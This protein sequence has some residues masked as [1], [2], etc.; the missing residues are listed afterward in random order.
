M[1][2]EQVLTTQGICPVGARDGGA[3]ET[4]AGPGCL[5]PGQ[6]I[7]RV[8]GGGGGAGNRPLTNHA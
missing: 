5:E 2:T 3:G 4:Q 1:G 8:L 7:Q 6:G